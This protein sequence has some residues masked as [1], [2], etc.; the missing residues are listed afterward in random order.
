MQEKKDLQR[1]PDVRVEDLVKRYRELVALDHVSLQIQPGEIFGLLG[2]NGSGKT[3]LMNCVLG[4]LH[5]DH[6]SVHVFGKQMASD[7]YALKRQIGYVPQEI[8]LYEELNVY[9]NIDYYCGLYVSDRQQRNEYVEQVIDFVQLDD[10]RK[11]RPKKLSGGLRRRLNLACGIAHKPKL[12]LLDEPTVAVDPQSRNRILEGIRELRAEG[13]TVIYTTHYMEEVEQ[14]CDRLA[15]LDHGKILVSG[16]CE[17]ILG[18]STV[19][20]TITAEI[21]DLPDDFLQELEARPEIL[22]VRYHEAE[23]SIA[24]RTA[25]YLLRVLH[26]LESRGRE[27][28]R[29]VSQKPNLNDVFLQITGK[30]LRDHE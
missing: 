5:F 9:E 4:L 28:V 15:I 8:I 25:G 21:Y 1:E 23:L 19:A 10:F 29:I 6:G 22:S 3:T 18:M 16:T 24:S 20:E 30:E 7:A 27:P 11:F 26:D 17:E 12:I 13:A 14:L 2:P